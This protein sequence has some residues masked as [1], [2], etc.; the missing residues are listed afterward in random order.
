[1]TNDKFQFG[2]GDIMDFKKIFWV[3]VV[4]ALAL[5]ANTAEG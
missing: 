5:M 1:V 2:N 3:A 4:A